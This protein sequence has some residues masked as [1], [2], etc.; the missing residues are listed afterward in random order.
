M[1]MCSGFLRG[2]MGGTEGG[3]AGERKSSLVLPP[4]RSLL[5]EYETVSYWLGQGGGG[6]G[7]FGRRQ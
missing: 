2:E 3:G 6:P 4:V 1:T 5:N 7:A